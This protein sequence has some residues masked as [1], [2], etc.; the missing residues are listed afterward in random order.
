MAVCMRIMNFKTTV[1]KKWYRIFEL[2]D[3]SPKIV[4]DSLANWYDTV[5]DAEAL[6]EYKIEHEQKP[7]FYMALPVYEMREEF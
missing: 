1:M 2:V 6:I 5:E 3:G 7:T 4:E